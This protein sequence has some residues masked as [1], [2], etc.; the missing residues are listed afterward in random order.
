MAVAKSRQH[1]DL[2]FSL[3][4][5]VVIFLICQTFNPIR[6]ILETSLDEQYLDC[7][8]VYFYYTPLVVVAV[9]FNSSINFVVYVLCGKRFRSNVTRL[10]WKIN[11]VEPII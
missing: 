2:T 8:S 7:G 3:V 9:N 11:V 10:F 1:A 5:I 4:V 6:R